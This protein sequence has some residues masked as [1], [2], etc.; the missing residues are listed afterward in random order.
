MTASDPAAAWQADGFV[1][2]PG[3]L[4][5][6]ELAPAVAEL[7]VMFPSADGFHDRTDPRHTRYRGDEFAGIDSFPFAS[8]EISLLAVHDRLTGLA[9]MLLAGTDIRIYSAEAW[10]KYT[11][12]ADYDQ[13]LHRDYLNHTLLVPGPAP[14]CQ[15]LEMFVYLADV[16]DELGP[17][18]LVSRTRTAGLPAKPNWYPRADGSDGEGG[19]VSER[20]HPDLYTAEVS[21]AGPAGTVVAFQAGTF[22]R[23]TALTAP[24]AARYTMHLG[25]RPAAAEWAHRQAWADRSHDPAWYRFVSR[26]TPRQLQLFGFPPPGHPFWTAETAAGMELRYPGRD[27]SAWLARPS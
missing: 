21:A 17:P 26:A 2:L 25:Y 10:A 3:F 22:H 6:S 4:P 18:H 12:A 23:G 16:P 7:G 1:V 27:W 19:F 13:A 15:Q 8:A 9:E 11:G 14:A 24:R 20:G 5:A